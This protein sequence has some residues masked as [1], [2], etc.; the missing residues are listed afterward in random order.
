MAL[1]PNFKDSHRFDRIWY[2]FRTMH[3]LASSSYGGSHI[4]ST[5]DFILIGGDERYGKRTYGSVHPP[6]VSLFAVIRMAALDLT[7]FIF[8]YECIPHPTQSDGAFVYDAINDVFPSQTN[9]LHTKTASR[10]KRLVFL[11]HHCYKMYR[12]ILFG[13]DIDEYDAFLRFQNCLE[14][15]DVDD[16]ETLKIIG[17][18]ASSISL[19]D[20]LTA[21]VQDIIFFVTSTRNGKSIFPSGNVDTKPKI[22]S[23]A[24]DLH[25]FIGAWNKEEL[26]FMEKIGAW[27]EEGVS[28]TESSDHFR[29]I[30]IEIG[31][32][33]FEPPSK[34]P[35]KRKSVWGSTSF[36]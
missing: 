14:T 28:P 4:L 27:N 25:H 5:S 9:H 12:T 1:D 6:H 36:A 15:Q 21:C 34:P 20:A 31:C 11:L 24:K 26:S 10:L 19:R 23:C 13:D 22:Q 3:Q 35:K 2:A 7:Q 18:K 30:M 17:V 16:E 33:E 8:K 32:E 29:K